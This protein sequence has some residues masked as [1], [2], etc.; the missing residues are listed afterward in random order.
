MTPDVSAG[1][2][3]TWIMDNTVL[4]VQRFTTTQYEMVTA[5]WVAPVPLDEML[6]LKIS[7]KC[8]SYATAA[9]IVYFDDVSLDAVRR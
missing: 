4:I 1:C 7:L 9:K 6:I 3:I 8:D 5:S 2:E